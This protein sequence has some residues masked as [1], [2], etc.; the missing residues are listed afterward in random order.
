MIS[1][2]ENAILGRFCIVFL[3]NTDQAIIF[4]GKELNMAATVEGIV[5][6]IDKDNLFMSE[7]KDD[8]ITK[9]ISRNKIS[10]IHVEPKSEDGLGV[11]S[12]ADMTDEG[13]EGQKH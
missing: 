7:G 2:V 11:V 1:S 3:A 13:N 6:K 9:V 4:K 8:K 12:V 5:V 10:Y